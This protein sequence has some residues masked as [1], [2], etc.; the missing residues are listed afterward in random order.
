MTTSLVPSR[1]VRHEFLQRHVYPVLGLEPEDWPPGPEWIDFRTCVPTQF[2]A[3]NPCGLTRKRLGEPPR[4]G[5]PFP[6]VLVID[7]YWYLVDGHTR[8]ARALRERR[9][10]GW[11]KVLR[12]KYDDHR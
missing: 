1:L 12:W 9:W 3:Y 11:A 8:V 4:G 2:P 6:F 5:S 10:Y 7:E